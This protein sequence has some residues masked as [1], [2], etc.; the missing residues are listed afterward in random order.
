MRYLL[1][2]FSVLVFSGCAIKSD[3]PSTPEIT[4]IGFSKQNIKA[5]EDSFQVYFKFK[6]LEG[7]LGGPADTNLS[8]Y[9][10]DRFDVK[11]ETANSCYK[12]KAWNLFITEYRND[13]LNIKP[14]IIKN[15]TLAFI[16]PKNQEPLS[17]TISVN[18]VNLTCVPIEKALDTIR[19]KIRIKDQA[20]NLSNTIETTP[21]YLYQ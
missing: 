15:P 1:L 11:D 13:S 4:F 3:F 9:D 14:L 16:E 6:D 5:N 12:K 2:F 8:A 7:D 20:G 19:F 17:G 18:L 10:C 21:V